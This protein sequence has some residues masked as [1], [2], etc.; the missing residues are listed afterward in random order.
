M[1]MVKRQAFVYV[2]IDL[3][4]LQRL[5]NF[6]TVQASVNFLSRLFCRVSLLV[7]G[8][9]SKIQLAKWSAFGYVIPLEQR[10]FL[11]H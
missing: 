4:V 5:E 1:D 11:C 9:L 6:L 2:V 8:Y 10:N 3:W 7:S